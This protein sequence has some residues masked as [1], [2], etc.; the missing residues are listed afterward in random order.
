M[1]AGDN[2]SCF[3]T[4]SR[5]APR[6]RNVMAQEISDL[7]SAVLAVTKELLCSNRWDNPDHPGSAHIE[8]LAEHIRNGEQYAAFRKSQTGR[9]YLEIIEPLEEAFNDD[10]LPNTFFGLELSKARE[11][12]KLVSEEIEQR[13][14]ESAIPV[15]RRHY[16]T[17]K[18]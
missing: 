2:A 4:L 10:W 1:D 12:L 6:G 11:F 14:L 8:T 3:L 16:S 17:L 13:G 15:L 5:P 9:Y 7:E 18:Q